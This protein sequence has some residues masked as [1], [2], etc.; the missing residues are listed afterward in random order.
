M[1]KTDG[2]QKMGEL[3]SYYIERKTSV[4]KLHGVSFWITTTK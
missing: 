2:I 3:A 1:D 4:K